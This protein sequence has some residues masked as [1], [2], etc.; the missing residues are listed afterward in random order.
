MDLITYK[1]RI[2]YLEELC[3]REKKRIKCEYAFS[4]NNVILGTVITDKIG[5]IIV[6]EIKTYLTEPP[7]CAYVGLISTCNGVIQKKEKYRTIYQNN[8]IKNE[9]K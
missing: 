5:S 3:E 6:K 1:N 2:A 4:N 8:I 9:N 7:Q